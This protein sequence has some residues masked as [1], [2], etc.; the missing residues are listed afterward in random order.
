MRKNKIYISSGHDNCVLY[1]DY[2]KSFWSD[3]Q[4][5]DCITFKEL[6]CDQELCLEGKEG[7]CKEGLS[8]IIKI[9]EPVFRNI[10]SFTYIIEKRDA[11]TNNNWKTVKQEKVI[12]ENI[13]EELE[14]YFKIINYDTNNDYDNVYGLIEYRI[15][16]KTNIS[17]FNYI[18]GIFS[19]TKPAPPNPKVVLSIVGKGNETFLTNDDETLRVVISDDE[20]PFFDTIYNN[21]IINLEAFE[22]NNW[23]V[24]DTQTITSKTIDFTKSWRDVPEQELMFRVKAQVNYKYD[25]L[26]PSYIES[27]SVKLKKYRKY[28]LKLHLGF[29]GYTEDNRMEIT[30]TES[31]ST[32]F[33]FSGYPY[34]K[35]VLVKDA[36]FSYLGSFDNMN[37]EHFA[38][39]KFGDNNQRSFH[40]SPYRNS[41]SKNINEIKDLNLIFLTRDVYYKG[42]ATVSWIYDY[43]EDDFFETPTKI[44]RVN[45]TYRGVDKRCVEEL[46]NGQMVKTN[47]I[48]YDNREV[49]INGVVV[50]KEPN[51]KD[52]NWVP[53]YIDPLECKTTYLPRFDNSLFHISWDATCEDFDFCGRF[54]DP[55]LNSYSTGFYCSNVSNHIPNVFVWYLDSTNKAGKESVLIDFERFIQHT[56]YNK[57]ILTF[58]VKGSWYVGSYY[59]GTEQIT[60]NGEVKINFETF[61]GGNIENP[62]GSKYARNVGGTQVS[63]FEKNIVISNTAKKAE[64]MVDILKIIYNT[65]TKDARIEMLI[66]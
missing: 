47:E 45:K 50:K 56:N 37:F 1:T 39:T 53:S 24:K 59:N 21:I 32:A 35:D 49:L 4:E 8:F 38:N 17:D 13:N 16:Y 46:R 54:E 55:A 22:N 31:F 41:R 28:P 29:K 11:S 27:N 30:P 57:E 61:L 63:S 58:V 18:Q 2:V 26:N 23:V 60:C 52:E 9:G 7:Q 10:N 20:N 43:M 36:N 5:A 40:F 62:Q 34:D 14:N 42:S 6:P 65:I 64:G 3:C 48:V 19:C 25:Y 51:I 15:K 12:L 44:V 33:F 66:E